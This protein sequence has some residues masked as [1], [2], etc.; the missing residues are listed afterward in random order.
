MYLC[1]AWAIIDDFA[2]VESDVDRV[3]GLG[4]G[5]GLGAQAQPL[6]LT[7]D[8][9]DGVGLHGGGVDEEGLREGALQPK[10]VS[11]SMS[12]RKDGNSAI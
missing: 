10:Y 2:A 11:A 7:E 12:Y 6:G 9:A 4:D 3:D 1:L 8:A 5:G